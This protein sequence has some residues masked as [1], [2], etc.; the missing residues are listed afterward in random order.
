MGSR[1]ADKTDQIERGCQEL[2][3]G[4]PMGKCLLDV[5]FQF[6]TMKKFWVILLTSVIPINS[7][8]MEK[9][10]SGDWL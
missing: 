1:V 10:N 6:C 8:K 9:K 2:G 7:M 4:G 5:E 3:G